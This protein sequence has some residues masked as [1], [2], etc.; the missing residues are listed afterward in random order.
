MWGTDSPKGVADGAEIA[1]RGPAP[2]LGRRQLAVGSTGLRA[3]FQS[4]VLPRLPLHPQVCPGMTSSPL[5]TSV[6]SSV[7]GEGNNTCH[8]GSYQQETK[9]LPEVLRLALACTLTDQDLY[10]LTHHKELFQLLEE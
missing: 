7:K 1:D 6:P 4:G 9:M 10:L 5:Y 2:A 8:G 3:W